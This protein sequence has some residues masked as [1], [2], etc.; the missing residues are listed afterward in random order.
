MAVAWG[1]TTII[2]WLSMKTGEWGRGVGKNAEVEKDYASDQTDTGDCTHIS[3][4]FVSVDD[5]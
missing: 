4:M 1:G 5:C 3:V 2:G